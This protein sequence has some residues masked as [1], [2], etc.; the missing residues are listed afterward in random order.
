MDPVQRPIQVPSIQEIESLPS[1]IERIGHFT[2]SHQMAYEIARDLRRKICIWIQGQQKVNPATVGAATW[3]LTQLHRRSPIYFEI[4]VSKQ[5]IEAP[6]LLAAFSGVC[7]SGLLQELPDQAKKVKEAADL[8]LQHAGRSKKA[9]KRFAQRHASMPQEPSPQEIK[10]AIEEMSSKVK[11]LFENK[12]IKE[13]IE[14]KYPALCCPISME[15]FRKP[16]LAKDGNT[17]EEKDLQ[18]HWAKNNRSPLTG[19]IIPQELIFNRTV[20]DH[21]EELKKKAAKKLSK[22]SKIDSQ[23][24]LSEVQKNA[25]KMIETFPKEY[26]PYALLLNTLPS[27]TKITLSNGEEVTCIQLVLRA[28]ELNPI[29]DFYV[30]LVDKLHD[31]ATVYFHKK[32]W[33]KIDLLL[34]AQHLNPLDGL[35]YARIGKLMDPHVP[36]RFLN[37][38]E[39]TA[40]QIGKKVL[41]HPNGVPEN[42]LKEV[43]KLNLN[44]CTCCKKP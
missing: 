20:S 26:V 35:I 42:I 44:N 6:S 27:T 37:G 29:A 30:L 14:S 19:E 33:R 9:K 7:D 24:L 28:I 18:A 12:F 17:Y 40:C 31:A 2:L 10:G 5:V 13:H 15:L 8:A 38:E 1:E 36:L 4:Y 25:L 16:M 34:Q 41:E 39:V 23:P 43:L 22:E 21:I 32:S 11:T 3:T